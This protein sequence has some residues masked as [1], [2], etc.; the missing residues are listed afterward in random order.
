[1]VDRQTCIRCERTKP[2]DDFQIQRDGS[3]ARQCIKCRT[4]RAGNHLS[5]LTV[6]S[7]LKRLAAGAPAKQVADDLGVTLATV[8]YHRKRAADR[9]EQES[10]EPCSRRFEDPTAHHLTLPMAKDASR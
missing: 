7:I 2:L 5:P 3:R 4:E 10:V 6:A 8:Y 9:A 1:M